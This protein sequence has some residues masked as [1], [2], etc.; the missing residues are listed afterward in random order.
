VAKSTVASIRVLGSARKCSNQ[1]WDINLLPW[2]NVQTGAGT[3]RL[4]TVELF[5]SG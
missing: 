4:P 5:K 2:P 3:L 1:V